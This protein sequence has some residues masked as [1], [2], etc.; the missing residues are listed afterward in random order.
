MRQWVIG[1]RGSALA[2]WQAH[3]VRDMLLRLR[4]GLDVRVRAIRSDGD[5]DRASPLTAVTAPGFFSSRIQR[6]LRAG[7]VDLAV[8]SYKDLSIHSPHGLVVAA[9]PPRGA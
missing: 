5:I 9:V 8:H 6:A 7:E 2:M 3:H 1:S 4:E